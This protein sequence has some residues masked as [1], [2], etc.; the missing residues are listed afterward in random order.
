MKVPVHKVVGE[1]GMTYKDGERLQR[2]FREA[3]DRGETVEL[4]FDKTRIFVTAFFDAAVASL[5]ENCSRDELERKLK[6]VNL[7]SAAKELLD[8][9]LDNADRHYP[10]SKFP[11]SSR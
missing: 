5:L 6:I 3:F 10:R 8:H 11:G 9:S 1:G 7:P 2:E 4:G